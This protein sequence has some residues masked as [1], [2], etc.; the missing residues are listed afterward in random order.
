VAEGRQPNQ[1]LDLAWYAARYDDVPRPPLEA[2][3]HF[4]LIGDPEGRAA[5]PTFDGQLYRRRYP[6]VA[7]ARV[8]PLL[9]YLIN[10]RQEGRQVPS[11][12]AALGTFGPAQP[13]AAVAVGEA[14]P[15]DQVAAT[16][17]YDGLRRLLDVAQQ[18]RKDGVAPREP[19]CIPLLPL[20]E[21][22]PLIALPKAEAPR[23]SILIAAYNEADHTAAC[24]R[25]IA[26]A[27][28]AVPFEV[29]LA[30]DASSDPEMAAFA[31]VANVH[32]LR[33][34]HNIGFLRNCNAAFAQCHGEYV[35]LLNNDSQVM[36]GA[37][38][39]LVT[40]LDDAPDIAAAGPKLFYPNGR[41]QEAGCFIR[42]HTSILAAL[43]AAS[44]FV[45]SSLPTS[46][47]G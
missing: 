29:V 45:P 24:L 27:E 34:P 46:G 18:A 31:N 30:D 4:V 19:D 20:A 11:E 23:V 43:V 12:R 22:L 10:G 5:G 32:D 28:P 21:A 6:D 39:A 8:P 3:R 17:S 35:L 42:Q 33:Q 14:V 47:A 37:I 16:Q 25:S 13:G 44:E 41:L 7:D 1:W 26:R 15:Y 36:P 9:H 2:L 38:E 40:A